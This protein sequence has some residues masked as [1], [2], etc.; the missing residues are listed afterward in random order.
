M[1]FSH[2]WLWKQNGVQCDRACGEVNE[3]GSPAIPGTHKAV[4]ITKKNH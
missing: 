1:A 3:L 2:S 4:H